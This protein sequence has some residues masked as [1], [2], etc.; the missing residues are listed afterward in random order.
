MIKD[1]WKWHVIKRKTQLKKERPFFH[2]REVWMCCLGANV[3]FEQDGRGEEFLRPILIF[4]KC[5]NEV[6]IGLP[7]TTSHKKG[8]YYF[9][10]EPI[11]EKEHSTIILSQV[12]LIDAKRLKYKIGTLNFTEFEAT[13][14]EFLR[15]FK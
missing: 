12:R 14:R 13:K 2:E 15:L 9:P 4:K 10:I 8:K 11:A 3:G 5:N 7:L 1:F 6:F